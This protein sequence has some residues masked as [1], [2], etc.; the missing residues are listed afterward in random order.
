MLMFISILPVILATFSIIVLKKGTTFSMMIGALFGIGYYL[1]MSHFSGGALYQTATIVVAT[2]TDN[3]TILLNILLLFIMVYLIRN[4][5]I[6]ASFNYIVAP[7]LSSPWRVTIA[8]VLTA[9][10]FSL[11]D[12]LVCIA[13][14]VIFTDIAAN[15]GFSKAKTAYIINLLAVSSCCISPFSSWM[16][17]IK[18]AIMQSSWEGDV[19]NLIPVNYF[20]FG[21]VLLA[22][23]M[24]IHSDFSKTTKGNL[25]LGNLT[26]DNLTLDSKEV[27][28]KTSF[29]MPHRDLLVFGIIIATLISTMVIRSF[30]FKSDYALIEATSASILITVICFLR[31]DLIS[32]SNVKLSFKQALKTS[33]D[34]SKML[35]AIW[36]LS[37]VSNRLL[38]L[39]YNTTCL[40]NSFEY[41]RMLLP[42]FIYLLS[43]LYAFFTGSAFGGFAIFVPMAANLTAG[44]SSPITI[45][46]IAAAIS[47]SLMASASFS[48]DTLKL[49]AENT[50]ADI[51]YLQKKQLKYSIFNYMSGAIAFCMAGLL[52]TNIQISFLLGNAIMF[53]SLFIM[54]IMPEIVMT[55][56]SPT[57]TIIFD[58]YNRNAVETMYVNNS[59]TTKRFN[60]FYQ[61]THGKW[62]DWQMRN[63]KRWYST[64]SFLQTM[65]H[66]NIK[67]SLYSASKKSICTV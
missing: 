62:S 29:R 49:S 58:M 16:P 65:D 2:F 12:Y 15:C 1:F 22:V 13:M 39:S 59:N 3:W 6:M 10:L 41:P 43:G 52:E 24:G 33:F 47:G 46:S 34:L 63:R 27:S 17:V 37:N 56:C 9:F 40:S 26:L 57:L 51:N 19:L 31:L 14:G 30:I 44:N 32:E 11:D 7:H 50:G 45:L 21:G 23:F 66:A 18:N 38:C 55:L 20:A 64:I 28:E 53:T 36:L 48:S 35:L 5:R 4:S 67:S 61:S 60:S 25:S 8:M 42:A 54:N